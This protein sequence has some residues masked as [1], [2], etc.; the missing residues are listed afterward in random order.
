MRFR[1][2]WSARLGGCNVVLGRTGVE[3]FQPDAKTAL[4]VQTRL[5]DVPQEFWMI[6]DP[7]IEPIVFRFEPD[8]NASGA[9]VSSND[10]FFTCSQTKVFR[11]VVLNFR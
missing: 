8:K 4:Q 1:L 9:T 2:P 10:D 7:V 5:G 11:Q 6:L 3:I